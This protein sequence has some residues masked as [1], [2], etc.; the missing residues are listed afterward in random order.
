MKITDMLAYL[1]DYT[2]SE[3]RCVYE[4]VQQ[5]AKLSTVFDLIR[6]NPSLFTRE[7]V[8]KPNADTKRKRPRY[9]Y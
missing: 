9:F 5:R 7:P 1:G 2:Q 3:Y 8:S 4:Y 6:A